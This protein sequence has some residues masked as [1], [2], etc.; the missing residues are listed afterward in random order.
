[1]SPWFATVAELAV[2]ATGPGQGASDVL[3]ALAAVATN[4]TVSAAT[5]LRT[6]TAIVLRLIFA[7]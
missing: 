1:M 2:R 6:R 7:G 4:N 5:V 3:A